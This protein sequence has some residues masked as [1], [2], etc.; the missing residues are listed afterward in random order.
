MQKQS[1]IH[2]VNSGHRLKADFIDAIH[3]HICMKYE[4]A[5]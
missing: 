5:Y 4:I 3:F 1:K 2:D